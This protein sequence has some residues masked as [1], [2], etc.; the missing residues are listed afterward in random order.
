MA[1]LSELVLSDAAFDRELPR[2]VRERAR[3]YWTPVGVVARAIDSLVAHGAR[4]IL[5]VGCG[6]GKF[7]VVAAHLAPN[8]E[9]HGVEL[10]PRLVRLGTALAQRYEVSNVRLS[11]GDAT[12]L[13]WEAYDGLYFFNPFQENVLFQSDRFDDCVEFSTRRFG[14]DLLRAEAL[15]SNARVGTVVVTYHGL[16]GAIPASYEL[17]ADELAGSDRL[18]TWIQRSTARAS[19]A[20]LETRAGV[21]RVSRNDMRSGLAE[22]LC[23]ERSLVQD[24]Q[25]CESAEGP[26]VAR[27]V[28][29]RTRPCRR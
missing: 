8:A 19:F 1:P 11:W 5:D 25:P 3:D 26:A 7:C 10:R 15:L 18:R 22:L 9:V 6:P 13:A 2:Y 17:L 29:T 16:G 20:W 14:A 23:G 4:R 24:A 27:R 21:I 12:R 28:P